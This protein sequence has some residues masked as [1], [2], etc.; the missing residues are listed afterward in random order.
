MIAMLR[1]LCPLPVLVPWVLQFTLRLLPRLAGA[2]GAVQQGWPV[3][4]KSSR[5]P[6]LPSLPSELHP[7]QDASGTVAGRPG[8][9]RRQR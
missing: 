4:P 2:A 6:P 9:H 1:V 3:L 5:E 8:A 7:S